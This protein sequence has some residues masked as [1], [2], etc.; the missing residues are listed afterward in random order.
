MQRELQA[1]K[2]LSVQEEQAAR[3][4][5]DVIARKLQEAQQ[6]LQATTSVSQRYETQ[7]V[8]LSQKMST[9]EQLLIGQRQKGLQL[10]SELSAA[11]DRI[12]GAERRARWLEEENTKIKGELQS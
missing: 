3:S 8:E 10:E 1:Q 2:A 12:G 6:T 9:L 4:A 11:Q 5:Q 7:I